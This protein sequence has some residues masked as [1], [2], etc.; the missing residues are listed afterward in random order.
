MAR[1]KVYEIRGPDAKRTGGAERCV[2][3]A[4]DEV[5]L[6]GRRFRTCEHHRK[7]RWDLFVDGGWLYTVDPKAEPVKK[8]KKRKR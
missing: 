5:V 3:E 2:R 1:C 8:H 6:E 7:K 4:G